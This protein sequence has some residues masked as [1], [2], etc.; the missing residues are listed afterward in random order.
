VVVPLDGSPLAE[1]VLP[2]VVEL[3]K[4]TKFEAILIRA[5][6]LPPAATP[7]EYGAYTEELLKQLED[8]ARDYL[9]SKIDE[10]K[11]KGLDNIASVVKFG[12]G[13]EEII[14]LARET[15][16]NCIAMCTHGRSGVG[17]WVLGSVTDRVV[18]HSGDPVLIVRAM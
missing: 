4:K 12:F 8:E 1:Q 3:G 13:A 10:L 6:A 9:G 16:D 17:R 2:L 18:R 14:G 15:P 11:Q 5:Y 7:D